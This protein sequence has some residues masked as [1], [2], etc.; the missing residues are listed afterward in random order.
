M[1]YDHDLADRIREELAGEPDVSE[2]AMF[3]GLAFLAAGNMAVA[4]GS[5]GTMMV[6]IHPD[7]A[8][9]LLQ[10]PGAA[11]MIMRGRPLRGWLQI[12]PADDDAI[13]AW[14]AEGLTYA[15][16]LPAKR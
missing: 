2:R 13:A 1:A 6:R 9:Q 4:A 10:R 12:D 7:R 14:T 15:R 8:D 16:T 3:G 11:P 5:K